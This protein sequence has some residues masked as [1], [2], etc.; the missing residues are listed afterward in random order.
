MK[1]EKIVVK[2]LFGLFNHEI[3]LNM[4]NHITIIHGPNGIGK[5]VLL[6]LLNAF[7]IQNYHPLKHIPFSV[8]SV[9]FNDGSNLQIK[10]IKQFDLDKN[11]VN[12]LN[13]IYNKP[14][15]NELKYTIKPLKP[16]D[17][18]LPIEFIKKEFP[19]FEK[20]RA[21]SW[22][23]TKSSEILSFEEVVSRLDF[24]L[25]IQ[26]KESEPEWLEELRKSIN[27]R[28]VETKRL[29]TF[30]NI[31]KRRLSK[32]EREQM[33]P[34][35]VDYSFEIKKL[36][37]EKLAEYATLSQSLDRSFPTRLIKKSNRQ[38][39]SEEQLRNELKELEDKRSRLISAGLL[40]KEGE[41][42]FHELEKIDET[43]KNVLSVYIED[44]KAKL[45]VFDE[46]TNKIDLLI[47]IVNKRFLYKNMLISKN[48]GFI[49]DTSNKKILANELS[50]GEQHE[51]VMLYELLFKVDS[52]Y[53]ILID[54]PEIS[55]HVAWQQQFLKDLQEIVKLVN[56]DVLIA[57]HSP[58]IVH[59]RWDLTVEL[60]G[61]KK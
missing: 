45:K 23:D 20:I 18:G 40:D 29:F 51:L 15:S 49:F 5:T 21:E 2:D 4:E 12:D 60:K 6:T 43:N 32:Y 50:S 33:I 44:V 39:L 13:F 27:V 53:L 54:E 47:N 9:H 8:F 56:F 26:K 55:L 37:Q 48:D 3:P 42:D 14:N 28:F 11:E 16:Q 7:F 17:V 10:K 34:S 19:R 24:D 61:E 35:V 30:S 59:D 58:Q 46:L 36:I 52:T 41:I 38:E 1:I 31:R 22:L 25:P 57:T